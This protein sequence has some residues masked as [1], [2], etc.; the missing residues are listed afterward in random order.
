MRSL[1]QINTTAALKPYMEK[2]KKG[3]AVIVG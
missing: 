2:R 1:C 3:G